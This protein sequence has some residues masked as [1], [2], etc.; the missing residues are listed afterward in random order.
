[1]SRQTGIRTDGIRG[2]NEA[3]CLTIRL[4]FPVDFR[5]YPKS[6]AS[7]LAAVLLLKCLQLFHPSSILRVVLGS[8]LIMR[9]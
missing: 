4:F 7:S 9:Y 6:L 2:Q 5:E 3:E 8:L 1:M